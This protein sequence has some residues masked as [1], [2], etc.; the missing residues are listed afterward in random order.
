MED[1]VYWVWLNMIFGVGSRRIWQLM[2]LYESAH[3]AYNG[4][5][6]DE[7][8]LNLSDKESRNIR[9]VSLSEAEEHITGCAEKGISIAG[10]SD[11]DY[12]ARLRHIKNPPA[13]LY[14]KGNIGCLNGTRTVTAVGTRNA[15]EY[16]IAA[17]HRICRELAVNNVVIVSGFALG[18]DITA[19]MAAADEG[20]P[21]ACVLGCG[22]DV[23][24]PKGN[25][26]YRERILSSGGVFISE[27]PPGTR[28]FAPNFPK[29]NRILAAL[30]YVT[31]V[32]E[33]SMK[34]GSLITAGLAAE[35]GR[36][37]F[38]LPPADIF[39]SSFSGNSQLLRE[40]AGLLLDYRCVMDCFR[41]GGVLDSEIRS[42]ETPRLSTFGE[43]P[44][45][46]VTLPPA[47]KALKDAENPKISRVSRVSRTDAGTTD[48]NY[49]KKRAAAE[50]ER[51]S[52]ED[53]AAAQ[54]ETE[55]LTDIEKLICGLLAEGSMHADT[56][57]QKLDIDASELMV[58]LTELELFG[59][60]RSLPGK[61]FELV[62][63]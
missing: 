17:A 48:N 62:R 33:A 3:E 11:S 28:A 5:I 4:L 35:H 58:E 23:D 9:S 34:S 22:V 21:T 20:R 53:T 19:H 2:N 59:V 37:V 16:G 26:G 14:Y 30:G 61:L 41:I 50:N 6:T 49:E 60:I 8:G 15:S 44:I 27:F 54:A 12:P 36:D 51:A 38:V 46:T 13:V 55:E 40:G 25:L 10:Y 42:E 52:H 43:K 56:I 45:K 29:R 63:G 57:A 1:T 39:S 32:F 18:T 7:L 31:V 24:Y 47:E